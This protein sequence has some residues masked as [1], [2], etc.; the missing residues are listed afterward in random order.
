MNR[1]TEVLVAI[2]SENPPGLEYRACRDCIADELRRG[3]LE[4]QIFGESVQAFTGATGP[5]V[6]FHGHYDVVPASTSG[7]FRPVVG[8]G[9]MIGRGTADMKAGLA[10]MLYAARALKECDIPLRGRIGLSFVPDEETGGARGSR[11]LA[12]QGLL[13]RQGIA[14]LTPEPTGGVV[15]SAS[16]GAVSLRVSVTGRSAH[17]G[18]H[19]R[20]ANAFSAMLRICDRLRTLGQRVETRRTRFAISP[21]EA[22]HSVLLVGGTV[23]GGTNFNAVPDRCTFTVDRRFNPEESLEREAEALLD[24]IHAEATPGITISVDTLQQAGSSASDPGSAPGVALLGHARAVLGE[25]PRVE[26]CPGL[27]ETRFYAELGIPAFAYGPGLLRVAHGPEEYVELERVRQ[28][29]LIYALTAGELLHE[30]P[31]S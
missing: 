23:S 4:P 13:G 22:R 15:W 11:M 14:M 1:F 16:R 9:K 30:N 3:G 24:A 29:A 21:D 8:D 5:T 10:L 31:S 27:L 6:Y 12:D 7:Q 28:F 2:G 18:E 19:Y 17:V 25:S 20:G 26:L